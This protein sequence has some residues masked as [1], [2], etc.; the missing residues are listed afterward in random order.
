VSFYALPSSGNY[1]VGN[2][3]GD[4]GA[5]N[6]ISKV[7][8]EG[9]IAFNLVDLGNWVGSLQD[10][11]D[12]DGYWVIS[13]EASALEVQ[14][15]P[16]SVAGVDYILHEGNNFISYPYFNGNSLEAALPSINDIA[17]IYGEGTSALFLPNGS[18]VGSLAS[19]GFEGANGYWFGA[20]TGFAFSYN[21]PSSLGRYVNHELPQVPVELAYKQST[22]QYFYFIQEAQIENMDL[23]HGDWVV[24]YNNDV[25]VG[26]RM[27]D[28][29]TS[30]IDVP[31]MGSFTGSDLK[32]SVLNLTAGYCEPGD[33]P[34]IKVHKV[35]GQIIDMFVTAV[36]GSLAFSG[37]GHA[38]VTLSD[39]NFPQE[40]SLHN[41]YPNPFNPSTMIQ[42]DLPQGSMHVNLS[43][44]D[45]RGRLVSELVNEM[46]S[47]SSDAYSVMWNADTHSSGMYFV[48]LRAGNTVMNQKI[49]LL[50]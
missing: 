35:T 45:I 7:F 4:A 25:V 15:Y 1:G 23:V 34:S 41:A 9:S 39:V 12:E 28:E 33:I 42:Y 29:N 36:E 46:Q 43:V 22:E 26:A 21:A 8:G 38:I 14:G 44:F 49:M 24:A 31:I 27:Y 19:V 11:S 47:G 5:S 3:F 13:D 48:Q 20:S 6:N 18:I 30:M 32:S 2:I 37:M 50:K 17:Y 40:V 10:V 16:T